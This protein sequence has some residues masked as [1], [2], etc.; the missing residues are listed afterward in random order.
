MN[1]STTY[2]SYQEFINSE[3]NKISELIH[4]YTL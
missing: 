2:S 1:K 3:N 4:N